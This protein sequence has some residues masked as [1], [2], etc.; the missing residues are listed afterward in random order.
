[1]V[2]IGF[3]RESKPTVTSFLEEYILNLI[4]KA[5]EIRND[6]QLTCL[7]FDSFSCPYFSNTFK[8]K[9]FSIVYSEIS[10]DIEKQS[11]LSFITSREWFFT[12]KDN[13]LA[14]VLMKKE[15]RSPY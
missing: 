1:M 7:I 2:L 3:L 8:E 10:F 15:L 11:V 6:T 13:N 9:I 4:S 14:Q 5:D 12:W